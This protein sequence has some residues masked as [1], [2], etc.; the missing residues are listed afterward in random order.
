MTRLAVEALHVAFDGRPALSGVEVRAAAGRLIAVVGPN[1]AGKSTLLRCIAGLLSPTRGRVR[2]DGRPVDRLSARRRAAEIAYVPQRPSLAAPYSVR[3]TVALG[4]YALPSTRAAVDAALEAMQL[5]ALADRRWDTL[6][7]GQ[8]QRVVIARALAQL[9]RPGLL[10]LDEPTA[11]LDLRH[12]LHA[13]ALLRTRAEAGHLVLAA[14]HDLNLA[15]AYAH[16]AWLLDGGHLVEAGPAEQVLRPA[17]LE[18]VFGVRF[19]R[20]GPCLF[21]EPAGP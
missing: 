5:R 2:I 11:A 18:P 1:A 6:S 19:T 8:Q 7:A 13:L 12:G 10:I 16:E 14:L 9:D 20:H 15:A 4:R 21:P 3:E 17:R